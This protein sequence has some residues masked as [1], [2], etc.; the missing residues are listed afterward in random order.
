MLDTIK[1]VGDC[2]LGFGVLLGALAQL[3][4]WNTQR[5]NAEVIASLEKNTNSIK[6]ALVEV[7]GQSEHAKGVLAGRAEI[8]GDTR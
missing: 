3:F 5:R 8:L 7:T 4:T 1:T 2:A 6:D